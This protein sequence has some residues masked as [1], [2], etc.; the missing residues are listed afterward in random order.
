M[1]RTAARFEVR[2]DPDHLLIGGVMLEGAPAPS[3]LATRVVMNPAIGV[4]AL[5]V[6][7]GQGRSRAYL[8]LRTGEHRRLQGSGDFAAF[9]D[10]CVASGANPEWYSGAQAIGPLAM[11]EGAD[12]WIDHPYRDG[13]AL[14]GDAAAASDPSH[15]QGQSLTLRDARVLHDRLLGASDWDAA[16]QAYAAEHDRYYGALHRGEEWFVAIFFAGGAEAEARRA[17]ALPLIAGDMS[18][19]PDFLFSGPD[20]PLDESVRRRFFGEE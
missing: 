20:V 9:I 13:V 12:N 8:V 19:V 4:G 15:G 18:R 5:I 3:P 14:I 16:G 6:P 1:M 17:R 10:Q 7:T 2:R 11:F